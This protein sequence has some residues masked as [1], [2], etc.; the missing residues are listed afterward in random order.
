MDGPRRR[1]AAIEGRLRDQNGGGLGAGARARRAG[2]WLPSVAGTVKETTFNSYENLMKHVIKHVGTIK[3]QKLTPRHLTNMYAALKDDSEG[4]AYSSSTIRGI[5]TVFH[6]ALKDADKWGFV[7]R[8]QADFV[9]PPRLAK[10]RDLQVWTPEQIRDFLEGARADRLYP[11]WLTL[12][13]TGMRRGEAMGLRWIDF[14]ADRLEIRQIRVPLEH[15]VIVSEP[16]TASS[17]RAIPLD[18][19]TAGAIREWRVRQDWE[20]KR[21]RGAW[22]HTGLIFTREDGKAFH[23]QSVSDAF[24]RLQARHNDRLRT[25]AREKW[26]REGLPADK[27]DDE[28]KK[29]PL[30]PRIRLHDLRHSWATA[31]LRAGINP[32][33]VSERLGHT[34]VSIT[35]DIY[36]SVLPSMGQEAADIVA[37]MMV[38]GLSG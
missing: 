10:V 35:L 29:L 5:H 14:Q 33:V 11:L 30:L 9:R 24:Q 17:R 3:L 1:P 18:A 28:E 36:S 8:N 7:G 15:K 13:T 21:W 31:A 23:P 34:T 25:E 19:K 6:H 38:P 27:W 20:N 4:K 22:T 16:K 37:A 2:C 26:E 32:K 12:A